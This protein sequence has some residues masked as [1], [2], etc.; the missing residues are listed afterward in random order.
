M[1][2][3]T[4]VMGV[5]KP[6]FTS[7]GAP[8]CTKHGLNQQTHFTTNKLPISSRFSPANMRIALTNTQASANSR[9]MILPTQAKNKPELKGCFGPDM[10]IWL[11]VSTILKIWKSVGMI[12]P[13]IWKNIKCSKPPT[14]YIFPWYYH[15]QTTPMN[16]PNQWITCRPRLS[17]GAR[18][19]PDTC[20]LRSRFLGETLT[21]KL[22]PCSIW[23]S[24]NNHHYVPSG[25]VT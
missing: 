20:G 1:V 2:L 15:V 11:V 4:I 21:T 3:I 12:I 19:S 9:P 23:N 6:T 13:N 24:Y 5:Y 22:W 7:L 25:I 16:L 8:H 14:R 10:I 17:V 18:P